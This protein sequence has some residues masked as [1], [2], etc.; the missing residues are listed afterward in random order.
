MFWLEN[1]QVHH[2]VPSIPPPQNVQLALVEVQDFVFAVAVQ[3]LDPERDAPAVLF[4]KITP[5][6]DGA[7]GEVEE[8]EL[9]AAFPGRPPLAGLRIQE[10][11]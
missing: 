1:V 3:I 6:E 11:L 7:T 8:N 2:G 9:V 4:G 10:K 5:L